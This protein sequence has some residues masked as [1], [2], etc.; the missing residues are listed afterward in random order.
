[1]SDLRH[2]R[3]VDGRDI[4]AV[5]RE[6]EDVELAARAVGVNALRAIAPALSSGIERR[7]AQGV[8]VPLN[9]IICENRAD[10]RRLP[11]GASP[12]I[13]AGSDIT[14]IWLAHRLCD[15]GRGPDGAV[16]GGREEGS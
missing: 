16:H 10:A 8:T 4:A 2:A 14:A 3:A 15:V 11:P 1:M 6:L 5:A 13:P 7:A 12:E 9:I